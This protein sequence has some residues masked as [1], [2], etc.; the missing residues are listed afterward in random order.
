MAN[1]AI[2]LF[3]NKDWKNLLTK[4]FYKKGNVAIKEL[5]SMAIAKDAVVAE[6]SIKQQISE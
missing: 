5:E 3:I 4:E 1:D 2:E 6:E